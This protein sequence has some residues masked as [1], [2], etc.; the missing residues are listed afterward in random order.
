[1]ICARFS[2]FLRAWQFNEKKVGECEPWLG[3]GL[4][5]KAPH[6]EEESKSFDVPL[7]FQ[8]SRWLTGV[9]RAFL[10]FLL[11]LTL[12]VLE[13]WGTKAARSGSLIRRLQF[14]NVKFLS[15]LMT[16]IHK[17]YRGW[18]QDLSNKLLLLILFMI[19]LSYAFTVPS[20]SSVLGNEMHLAS[21]KFSGWTV[22]IGW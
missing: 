18:E 4:I 12:Q 3:P 6:G 1:M 7:M 13:C 17:R 15:Y 19:V 8:C 2:C 16:A 10:P 5:C 21:L 20:S 9:W 14:P 11:W 22:I